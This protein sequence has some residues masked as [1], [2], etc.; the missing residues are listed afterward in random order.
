MLVVDLFAGAGGLG[1]GFSIAGFKNVLS[2]E[3][4]ATFVDTLKLRHFARCSSTDGF[5]DDYYKFLS[6]ELKLDALYEKHPRAASK[7]I[8]ST[9]QYELGS[10]IQNKTFHQR[11]RQQVGEREFGLLGGPPCQAYSLAGR[12]RRLGS[13]GTSQERTKRAAEFYNDEKHVLYLNYLETVAFHKPAFFLM[14]NVKG[15]LSAK[16]ANDAEQ[17]SVFRDILEGLEKPTATLEKLGVKRDDCDNQLAPVE[18]RLMPLSLEAGL[19]DSEPPSPKPS[20]FVINAKHFGVPQSRERIFILG[21][22]EDINF[23]RIKLQESPQTNVWQT[24][25]HLPKLR[26]GLSKSEDNFENWLRAIETN[27][28]TFFAGSRLNAALSEVLLKLK[29]LNEPLMRSSSKSVI[30]NSDTQSTELENFLKDDNLGRWIQHETRGHLESDIIRYLYCATAAKELGRS[31]T[32]KDWDGNL[33]KLKPKHSNIK[34]GRNTLK[35][36][37]HLDRFKVQIGESPCSTITSHISKDGHYFIH[38]DPM[39]ARSLTVREAARI[40][41]FPDNYFF[42]GPRTEQ[43]IQVGNAVPPYLAYRIATAIKASIIN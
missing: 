24:I 30:I 29:A 17:G 25:G 42:C 40:Q 14:E 12:S 27:S 38:P 3:A 7:A 10:E 9:L 36:D 31:P 15:L 2:C 43:Y 26:S 6:G 37:I 16:K 35:T 11:L 8:S 19:L 18:Y 5:H 22:R 13:K 33:E 34:I 28:K 21:V 4:K 20:D 41:T 39:Q 1:E 32:L 23:H